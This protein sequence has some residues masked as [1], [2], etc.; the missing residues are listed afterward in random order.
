M[1]RE[2]N[3]HRI[4]AREVL[5]LASPANALI[6]TFFNLAGL[7]ALGAETVS[8]V[9]IEH[10]FG[11]RQN[12]QLSARH[13]ANGG[14]CAQI[15]K[16]AETFERAHIFR[17]AHMADIDR[18][19]R[20]AAPVQPEKHDQRIGTQLIAKGSAWQPAD[21]AAFARGDFRQDQRGEPPHRHQKG[22]VAGELPGQ[23]LFIAAQMTG[24]V[25]RVIGEHN[26]IF[27]QGHKCLLRA[28][29]SPDAVR[30]NKSALNLPCVGQTGKG[31][32][33]HKHARGRFSHNHLL[34]MHIR[35]FCRGAS[36]LYW[37]WEIGGRR[38]PRQPGQVRK[39]A[40]LTRSV[41]VACPVSHLHASAQ[42]GR[43]FDSA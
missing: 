35:G 17:V 29:T 21:I 10:A 9:P 22:G 8:H 38:I 7:P 41:R 16:H 24:S 11:L 32:W 25:E 39:E 23:P 43:V 27:W 34:A 20:F 33:S 13:I 36:L 2:H 14:Q 6:A 19:K 40:A 30:K 42:A 37:G 18:K 5:A 26:R 28:D 4:G 1:R 31:W 15:F 12:C 3:H